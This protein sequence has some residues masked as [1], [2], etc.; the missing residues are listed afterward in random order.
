M[1][2]DRPSPFQIRLALAV[3][4]VGAIAAYLVTTMATSNDCIEQNKAFWNALNPSLSS[5]GVLSPIDLEVQRQFA[6]R[7]CEVTH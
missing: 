6:E 7:M 4:G 5:K 2:P 1:D 3:V